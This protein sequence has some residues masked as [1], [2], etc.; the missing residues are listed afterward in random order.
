MTHLFTVPKKHQNFFI[1]SKFISVSIWSPASRTICPLEYSS[2]ARSI[3]SLSFSASISTILCNISVISTLTFI[4][5]VSPPKSS[6]NP[7]P[8]K[9][10]Q[11]HISQVLDKHGQTRGRFSCLNPFLNL[12][13]VDPVNG[14]AGK[15]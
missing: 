7:G 6:I 12:H 4:P 9:F 3:A 2:F 10:N 5:I 15:P 13:F 8:G 1:E 11:T 14:E